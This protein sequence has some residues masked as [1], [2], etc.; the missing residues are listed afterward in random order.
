MTRRPRV[1]V[2]G[3]SG[4]IGRFVALALIDDGRFQ[5]VVAGRNRPAGLDQN[6][7]EFFQVGDLNADT[8]WGEGLEDVDA[9]LHLAGIAHVK[10][11]SESTVAAFQQVNVDGTLQLA[12]QAL[13][14]GVRHFIFMSSIGVNGNANLRPFSSENTPSPKEA[15]AKSKLHAEFGLKSLCAAA[16]MAYTI[17][18]PPLVYGPGAPGN[19]GLL[20]TIVSK[21]M[22]LPLSGIPN[23]RSFVS[24]WNLADLLVHCLLR[25]ESR[26]K[27]FVVRDGQDVST[28]TFL[29]MIGEASGHKVRLI[30]VPHPVLKL[31][32]TL[33]G[34]RGMYDK[35]FDSLQV[36]DT[37][38]RQVL[39]WQ[40]PYTLQESL[41][42]CF[43]NDSSV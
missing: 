19:F 14:A 6:A 39:G 27:T 42:M 28:S 34:K 23:R 18:R 41:R 20:S 2:T 32:A 24:V 1:L 7:Y 22:P 25:E 36:D 8:D 4:F 17:V 30:R 5:P 38:T 33:L 16:P 12:Q 3:A 21:E 11:P 9:V 43:Q 29:K 40:P 31:G 15:Y 26:G 35:L 37:D 10:D 13:G